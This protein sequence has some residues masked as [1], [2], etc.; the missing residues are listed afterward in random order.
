MQARELM[1]TPAYTCGPN[2]P[3]SIAAQVMWDH[4]CGA[5]PIVDNRGHVTGIVTD[6]DLCM[7]AHI[8][9]LP[10]SA[11]PLETVMSR[12]VCTCK[13]EDDL[14]DV[15]RRMRERQVRR[16]P[17]IDADGSAVGMLS[18]ADIALGVKNGG[19]PKEHAQDLVNTV[20]AISEQR[21]GQSP[22][23]HGDHHGLPAGSF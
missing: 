12:H 17:I 21:N 18:L 13:P 6:R 19:A 5:V 8:R 14:R 3:A 16:V 2:D 7:A 22:S 11:I 20:M 4:D 10:L 1:T 9:G 23:G 15:E